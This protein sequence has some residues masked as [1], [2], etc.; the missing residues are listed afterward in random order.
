[1]K[2]ETKGMSE[3]HGRSLDIKTGTYMDS[4]SSVFGCKSRGLAENMMKKRRDEKEATVLL[5]R[6]PPESPSW[7]AEECRVWKMTSEICFSSI[8][9]C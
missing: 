1:M 2:P 9:F 8:L 7:S 4:R 6:P 5:A 3:G